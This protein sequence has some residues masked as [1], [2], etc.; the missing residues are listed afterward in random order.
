MSYF[1]TLSFDLK[2]ASSD[3]YE[4][5]CSELAKIG[6][7]KILVSDSAI[8][9]SLPTTTCAG[10]FTGSTAISVRDFVVTK[11][12]QAF[13]AQGLQGEIFVAVGG[14]WAWVRRIATASRLPIFLRT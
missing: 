1:V 11:S 4:T 3:D 13:Q 2:H 12:Q 14:D 6:V 8:Q 5:A 10:T 9:V 7:H